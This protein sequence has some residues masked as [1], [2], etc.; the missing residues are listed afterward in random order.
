MR[1][2][3]LGKNCGASAVWERMRG[4]SLSDAAPTPAFCQALSQ[5]QAGTE[6]RGLQASKL[7]EALNST[8]SDQGA[9]VEVRA[10]VAVIRVGAGR[11]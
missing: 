8:R 1:A 9:G 11:V 5:G 2:A 7:R 4:V 6:A 3:V 10:T